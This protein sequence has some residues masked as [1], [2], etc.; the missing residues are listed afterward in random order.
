M[1]NCDSC[2]LSGW[3]SPLLFLVC[4]MFL[5]CVEFCQILFLLRQSCYFPLYSSDI[6]Y[7]MNWFFGYQPPYIC[8]INSMWS[9]CAILFICCWT[10][11]TNSSLCFEVYSFFFFKILIYLFI[12]TQRE[13]E[14]QT[15]T[16]RERSRHHAESLT[17][18]LIQVLQDHTLACRRR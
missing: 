15:H 18:D 7:Y 12:E 17:W 8:G 3:E 5:S 4:W 6:V 2:C 11:F 10:Q 9:W 14:A 16:G 1:D 13:R